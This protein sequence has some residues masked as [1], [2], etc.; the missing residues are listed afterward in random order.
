MRKIDCK[1][2]EDVIDSMASS[3]SSSSSV[4][5]MSG[6][7]DS[8]CCDQNIDVK[9]E[10]VEEILELMTDLDVQ[11]VIGSNPFNYIFK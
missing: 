2:I 8:F 10:D 11:P 4:V 6:F 5:V 9:I 7:V 1:T 3:S